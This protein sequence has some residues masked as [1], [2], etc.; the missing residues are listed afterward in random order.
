MN[1]ILLNDIKDVL[2]CLENGSDFNDIKIKL[3]RIS[4]IFDNNRIYLSKHHTKIV[5][6]I[7]QDNKINNIQ[8]IWLKSYY[9][10]I[11]FGNNEDPHYQSLNSDK[12]NEYIFNYFHESFIYPWNKNNLIHEKL[13][14]IIK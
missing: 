11:I 10:A 1:K 14:P 6:I 12:I 13:A 4:Y 8:I 2:T 3:V 5:N 7:L 9:S